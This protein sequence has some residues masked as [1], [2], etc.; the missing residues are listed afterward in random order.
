[1]RLRL[2]A[3]LVLGL[4]LAAAP[5]ALASPTNASITAMKLT[6]VGDATGE[7]YAV[8]STGSGP[9]GTVTVSGPMGFGSHT[10]VGCTSINTSITCPG[11]KATSVRLEAAGGADD[12]TVDRN[13]PGISV[14]GGPG[15]DT[16]RA[17]AHGLETSVLGGDGD[18]TFFGSD[19]EYDSFASEPG[20]DTYHGGTATIPPAEQD[21]AAD[22]ALYQLFEVPDSYA[23]YTV[24][25]ATISL[26]DVAN[27]SDGAGATDNVGADI[28]YLYGGDGNDVLAAGPNPAELSGGAGDDTLSGS[29]Q[30]DRLDGNDGND[31]IFGNGGPDTLLDGDLTDG[32]FFA[33]PEPPTPGNDTLDGGA[34]DD[35]L[36]ESFGTDDVHG[37]AGTDTAEIARAEPVHVEITVP[38][39]IIL[40]KLTAIPLTVSLD[41]QANDGRTGGDEHDN[42]H[43]DIED[44]DGF[45]DTPYGDPN[46]APL[47]IT[48]SAGPNR[49]TGDL[50]ND[51]ID[52]GGGADVVDAGR[53]DDTVTAADGATD[54]IDC[55][56]GTDS[57]KADLPGLNAP[58]ADVLKACETVT[59]TPLPATVVDVPTDPARPKLTL[60]G[61]RT[62]KVKAFLKAWT[63]PVGIACDQACSAGGAA[64]SSRARLAAVGDLTIGSGTLGSATGKRTLKV[65]IARKYQRSLKR[66]LRTKKQ[67]R[68]GV[69]VAVAVTVTNA[70]GQS[71]SKTRRF[72]VRG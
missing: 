49:I 1:M 45:L 7:T 64:L 25:G 58:R 4:A 22:P 70:A 39:E 20:N 10:I 68:R 29:P 66:H 59:G 42:L 31:A 51:V 63:L 62:V 9:T 55:G 48:G 34:G 28:E 19:T 18:D 46:P 60:S 43:T 56:A 8:S 61:K 38:T 71:T 2:T 47:T 27:D 3:G 5:E 13:G 36:I 72:T 67:R 11:S 37:G 65:K 23:V 24:P 54:I 21:P 50:G 16:L 6:V 41:D 69:K 44:V 14:D 35:R 40:P 33:T 52:G 26:D 15:S 30:H 57:A 32:Y 17:G 53:G 12:I